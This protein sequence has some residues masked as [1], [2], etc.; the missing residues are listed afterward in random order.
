MNKVNEE[1][2]KKFRHRVAEKKK[3]RKNMNTSRKNIQ[4][5]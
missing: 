2:M 3:T 1:G 5:T 4:N